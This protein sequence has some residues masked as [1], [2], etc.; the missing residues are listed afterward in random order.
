[1]NTVHPLGFLPKIF[2]IRQRSSFNELRP[3]SLVKLERGIAQRSLLYCLEKGYFSLIHYLLQSNVCDVRERDSEGR[4]ALMYCCF[5]EN[6]SWTQNMATILLEFGAKIGDQDQNGL[7]A[8]HYAIITQRINLIRRYL[9]SIDFNLNQAIDIH[10]NT[11]LHYAA[12]TGDLNIIHLV[13]KAMKRYSVDLSMKNHFGLTAY[14]IACQNTNEVCQNFLRNETTNSELNEL[15]TTNESPLIFESTLD[16]RF[17]SASQ[18]H[19][20]ISNRFRSTTPGIQR[21]MSMKPPSLLMSANSKNLRKSSASMST[22]QTEKIGSRSSILIDPT[23]SRHIRLRRNRI[24]DLSLLNQAK[25]ISNSK[26]SSI[27]G[28][29][30]LFSASPSSSTWRDDFTKIFDRLQTV[31]TPSYRETIHPPLNTEIPAD[32]YPSLLATNDTFRSDNV[33]MQ[34]AALDSSQKINRRRSS[35]MVSKFISK[36]RK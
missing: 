16:R 3:V 1:M 6:D 11:C 21:N 9:T 2:T 20:T 18:T 8:L 34:S 12:S 26:T 10:G 25:T 27:N 4:T 30:G 35:V 13:L 28:Q 29:N 24:L 31:K 36:L 15:S 14:D 32:L 22:V 23:E 17:S 19:S 7:N 5:I 33:G